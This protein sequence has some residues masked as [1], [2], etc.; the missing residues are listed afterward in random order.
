MAKRVTGPEIEKLIQLLAKVP[1]LGP[2]SAR[3]AALHLIKKKEQLLGPLSSA[4]GEAYDKV[5]ICSRC[6]NVDTVDPCTVCTDLHRDQTML[7]VVEDVSDLWALERTGA[8]NTAYHVLGGTLSPLDGIG[9]DDLNIRGLIDRVNEGVIRE[10][11][12]AVNATVEGQTTA[13][14]ITDQLSGI[15]VK[16]TRLAH[17]VPVGGELDYLDEGTLTAALRARTVI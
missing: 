15:D 10:I 2:R 12:I 3:R 1:G 4:M 11:I 16:I 13:H 14:Y 9:P 8:M 17:G 7:I 6:G 5:K